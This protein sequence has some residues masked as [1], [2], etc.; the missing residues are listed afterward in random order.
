MR[1][2]H[3]AERR[4][5]LLEREVGIEQII[6]GLADAHFVQK[7]KE[8]ESRHAADIAAQAALG[9]IEDAREPL[10][11]QLF[12]GVAV[13][14]AQDLAH[15]RRG[16]GA[17]GRG[18]LGLLGAEALHEDHQ[19]DEAVDDGERAEDLRRGRAENGFQPHLLAQREE[20][21]LHPVGLSL[22]AVERGLPFNM[23]EPVYR[24]AALVGEGADVAVE[25]VEVV[26]H[27]VIL[28]RLGDLRHRRDLPR[29]DGEKRIRP[30]LHVVPLDADDAVPLADVEEAGL[31]MDQR[32]GRRLDGLVVERA[33][34]A[35]VETGAL[36]GL[37]RGKVFHIGHLIRPAP[38]GAGLPYALFRYIVYRRG[39][40]FGKCRKAR[41]EAERQR[42]RR[43]NLPLNTRKIAENVQRVFQKLVCYVQNMSQFPPLG[44][45]YLEGGLS[46]AC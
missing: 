10:E 4:G 3:I 41:R 46:H 37:H 39:D 23:R 40:P 24:V 33:Q 30:Q 28:Q 31:L 15:V 1:G 2:V 32:R 6:R 20:K 13:E 18:G 8:R 22:V 26:D 27:E 9:D 43:A 11:R 5:D 21:L 45:N 35:P 12:A 29:Q 16:G 38:D 42:A 17:V 19:L 7:V 34:L 25:R 14:I 44:A 36:K